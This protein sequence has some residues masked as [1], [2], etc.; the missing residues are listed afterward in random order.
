[1]SDHNTPESAPPQ[2]KDLELRLEA[3]REKNRKLRA[4]LDIQHTK[5][6]EL[7][8][9]LVAS[10]VSVE[11]E[12]EHIS[13]C[14]LRRLE[15]LRKDK[16][17]LDAQLLQEEKHKEEKEH[18][19]QKL[20]KNRVALERHLRLEEV[21][22]ADKLQKQLHHTQLQR[23]EL[24]SKVTAESA[25]LQ[26]LHD[27]IQSLRDGC[28]PSPALSPAKQ[29]PPPPLSMHLGGS[30]T[31]H[32]DPQEGS[33]GTDGLMIAP[34]SC[35][36]TLSVLRASTGGVGDTAMD[37]SPLGCRSPSTVSAVA[38]GS[39]E[40][41]N[42]VTTPL[43][44][45]MYSEGTPLSSRRSF[46]ADNGML[47]LLESEIQVAESLRRDAERRVKEYGERVTKLKHEIADA[48]STREAQRATSDS[49]RAEL[50]RTTSAVSEIHANQEVAAEWTL[51]REVLIGGAHHPRSSSLCSTVSSHSLAAM[52]EMI[53]ASDSTAALYVPKVLHAVHHPAHP[54]QPTS[55][56]SL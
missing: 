17:Q 39:R 27:C 18:L 3:M 43:G 15:S 10:S 11:M 54:L 8:A 14:L 49:M 1:M 38:G 56:A 2:R 16:D 29:P 45:S 35:S 4:Q 33:S 21:E 9:S 7:H 12:E 22:I 52:P 50:L 19:L 20:K 53:T 44:G 13:N 32:S 55:P 6:D 47:R 25:T 40:G 41:G 23:M 26:Q 42:T 36:T 5:N 31:C 28:R 46:T 34:L 37:A 51:D 30:M 48:E 24:Q